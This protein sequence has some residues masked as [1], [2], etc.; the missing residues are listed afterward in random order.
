M[1]G[2]GTQN[3]IKRVLAYST[4]SQIGYMFAAL[5]VAGFAAAM[6]HFLTHAF[7]KALLFLSAGVVTHCVH[8]ETDIRRLGGLRRSRALAGNRGRWRR[9][10]QP[11]WPAC[12]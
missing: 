7:F 3:D 6:F 2:A 4:V 10:A 11:P 8:G 12:P 9:S 5:G 1:R